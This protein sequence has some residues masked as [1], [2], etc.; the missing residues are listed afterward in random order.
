MRLSVINSAALSV[1][2]HGR[3]VVK[4]AIKTL[5]VLAWCLSPVTV[6]HKQKCDLIKEAEK[7]ALGILKKT[8]YAI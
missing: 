2:L 1:L 4:H 3:R 6:P 7:Q 8:I 5:V